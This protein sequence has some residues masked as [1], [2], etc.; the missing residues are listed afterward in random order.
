MELSEMLEIKPSDYLV[1]GFYNDKGEENL[2]G[3]YSLAM[4]YR[5]REEGLNPENVDAVVSH[6]DGIA[7]KHIDAAVENPQQAVDPKLLEQLKKLRNDQSVADSPALCELLD[8]AHPRISN[9][10]DY[11]AF[12]IHLVRITSQLALLKS[13]PEG[14]VVES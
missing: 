5:I 2:N 14:N 1:N 7:E 12:V 3:L 11:S 9:W 10:K 8:A 13:L 6:L 4:A